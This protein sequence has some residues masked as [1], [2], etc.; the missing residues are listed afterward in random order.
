MKILNGAEIADFIKERQAHQVRALRQ[1]H[2][3]FPKLAILATTD[4]PVIAK[5][6]KAKQA[7]G[8]EILVDVDYY[9]IDQ[10]DL[11]AK[12]KEL[13]QDKS[14]HGIIV[15]LP[16][17]NPDETYK[18]VDLVKPQKDVDGLGSKSKFD[19]CTPVAILWLLSAYNIDLTN[20][21]IVI[22]GRGRLVGKPLA[23]MMQKS[24]LM[25]TVI[26]SETENPQTILDKAQII[27]TS[28]GQSG[29]L[30][31]KQIPKQCIVIDAGTASDSGKV[32]GDLEEDV[33]KREDLTITP[34]IGGVGP[35]TVAALFDNLIRAAAP[36]TKD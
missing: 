25:P 16:L 35:L 18:I 6:V 36:K 33:Y 5:Y 3:I 11:S 31:S 10:K 29:F 23:E 9:R 7:Y 13:N 30:K 2:K 27:I 12:I 19:C 22:I 34:K 28:T 21:N 17:N 4:N 26:H 15:Q 1:A 20:K 14:V 24:G 8:A 32:K